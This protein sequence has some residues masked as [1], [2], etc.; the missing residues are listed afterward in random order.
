MFNKP[1]DARN[2]AVKRRESPGR[3]NPKE[4]GFGKHNKKKAD[5]SGGFYK[6][7]RIKHVINTT[8]PV[9]LNE[10]S[11]DLHRWFSVKAEK[12]T[13]VYLYIHRGIILLQNKKEAVEASRYIY[14]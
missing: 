14:I 8:T 3:K 13:T 12:D 1:W 11:I 9:E 10:A 7:C 6:K 4:T 5:I 2:P